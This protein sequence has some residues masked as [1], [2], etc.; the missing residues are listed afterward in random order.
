LRVN[1]KVFSLSLYA[2]RLAALILLCLH[3]MVKRRKTKAPIFAH[4]N[5]RDSLFTSKLLKRL[6][7]DAEVF[8]GLLSSEQRFKDAF[9]TGHDGL[10]NA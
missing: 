1:F 3:P 4:S 9:G 5:A 8:S 2:K 10:Y 6:D 7:V